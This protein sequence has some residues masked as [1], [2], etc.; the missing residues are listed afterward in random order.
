MAKSGIKYNIAYVM[1]EMDLL[2]LTYKLEDMRAVSLC[3]SVNGQNSNYYDCPGDGTYGFTFDYALPYLA[4]ES[5]MSWFASGFEGTGY[6]KIYA[7]M[8]EK[9]MIGDCM[10]TFDTFVTDSGARVNAPSA[11]TTA[12]LVM[13]FIA[14]A[15]VATIL[16]MCY[17]KQNKIRRIKADKLIEHLTKDDITTIWKRLD[18]ETRS[19][20]SVYTRDTETIASNPSLKHIGY[21]SPQAPECTSINSIAEEKHVTSITSIAEG[22]QE[23]EEEKDYTPAWI[24]NPQP[25][26]AKPPSSKKKKKSSKRSSKSYVDEMAL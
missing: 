25:D 7:E 4:G 12:G 17:R 9:M 24:T 26:G 15:I 6:I 21:T 10:F 23:D 8:D 3:N 19:I 11:A 22:Q 13:A 18:D 14:T 5:R 1:A 2:G 20:Q 16:L